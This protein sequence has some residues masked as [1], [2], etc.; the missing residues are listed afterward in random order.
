MLKLTDSGTNNVREGAKTTCRRIVRMCGLN[1]IIPQLVKK[2]CDSAKALSFQLSLLA[3]LLPR[4]RNSCPEVIRN[5]V[6]PFILVLFEKNTE[7]KIL[8]KIVVRVYNVLGDQIIK[9]LPAQYR[10]KVIQLLKTEM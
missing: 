6:Y 1:K 2:P 8:S 9:T 7:E 3:E 5:G 4:V 10:D